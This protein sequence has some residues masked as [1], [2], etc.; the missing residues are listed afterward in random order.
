MKKNMKSISFWHIW[1]SMKKNVEACQNLKKDV[2]VW[3]TNWR[4]GG[5]LR[6]EYAPM[7]FTVIN[8]DA[9]ILFSAFSKELF[10]YWKRRNG[11]KHLL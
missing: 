10:P 8:F 9:A 11:D 4:R 6:K 1:E 3:F 7:L 5:S 2:H